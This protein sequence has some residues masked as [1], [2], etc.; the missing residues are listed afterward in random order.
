MREPMLEFVVVK[1]GFVESL[2]CEFKADEPNKKPCPHHISCYVCVMPSVNVQNELQ[3]SSLIN[4]TREK[5]ADGEQKQ[6]NSVS[7]CGRSL[8]PLCPST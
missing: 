6:R 5:N 8:A 3:R 4:I 7:L 1:K 2:I